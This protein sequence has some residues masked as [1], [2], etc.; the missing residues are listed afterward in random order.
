M[1][2]PRRGGMRLILIGL[3]LASVGACSSLHETTA[4]FGPDTDGPVTIVPERSI[5]RLPPDLEAERL[6]VRRQVDDTVMSERTVFAN[7]TALPGENEVVVRTRWRGTPYA[8]FFVGPLGNP[9][10]ER[11]VADRVVKEFGPWADGAVLVD[12]ENRRGPYRYIAA[13]V[14][15]IDCIYAWQVVFARAEITDRAET[16]AVDFRFCDPEREPEALLT[17]FDR[18][19][20]QPYL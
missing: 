16:Y 12:R 19:D 1:A 15:G 8:R 7:A 20:L 6:V 17:W 4:G 14:E 10:T 3:A 11:A 5:I 2:G 13:K 18:L 9:F